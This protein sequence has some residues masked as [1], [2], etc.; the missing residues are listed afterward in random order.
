MKKTFLKFSLHVILA[1]FATITVAFA[2]KP[3]PKTTDAGVVINGVKWAT[4]NVDTFGTFAEK[5]E[6][7]G[8]FY[9]WNRPKAWNATDTTVTSWDATVPTGTTWE[10]ANDPSP[11]GWRVPTKAEQDKLFDTEKVT[12]AWT[13]QNGVIGRE[14]TDRATGNSLFFPAVGYRGYS[15]GTLYYAGV[16]GYYWSSTPY[17]SVEVR[18]YRAFFDGNGANVGLAYRR[19]GFSVRCVLAE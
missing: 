1:L 16:L 4:R 12:N 8:M 7:A 3:D 9:Q 6:S 18:A 15:T 19:N 10:K 13:I 5:P 14:F 11:K 2:Q 17:D